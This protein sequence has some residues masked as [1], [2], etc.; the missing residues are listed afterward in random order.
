M[1]GRKTNLEQ[2]HI[3]AGVANRKVSQR[4]GFWVWLCHDC[5]TGTEGAQYDKEKNLYLK[6]E[7][8]AAF[9]ETHTRKEFMDL[10]GKNYL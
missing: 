5:H 7:A 9:E 8:Q 4:A 10:I 1:C 3:W 2:H 6:K